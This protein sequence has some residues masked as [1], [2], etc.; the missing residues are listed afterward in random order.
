MS[1]VSAFDKSF[2][3]LLQDELDGRGQECESIVCFSRPA[4]CD[5]C[6]FAI[7]FQYSLLVC[8][9]HQLTLRLSYPY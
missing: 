8:L 3:V 7:P 1:P 2:P 4:T 9:T 5:S 6:L